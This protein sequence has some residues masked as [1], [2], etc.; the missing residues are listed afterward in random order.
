[1]INANL[2]LLHHAIVHQKAELFDYMPQFSGFKGNLQVKDDDIAYFKQVSPY[3]NHIEQSFVLFQS[4]SLSWLST[5]D[6]QL[7]LLFQKYIHHLSVF[8]ALGEKQ[9][10]YNEKIQYLENQLNTLYLAETDCLFFKQIK[11][12]LHL[13]LNNAAFDDLDMKYLLNIQSWLESLYHE[14][15]L[16]EEQYDDVIFHGEPYFSDYTNQKIKLSLKKKICQLIDDFIQKPYDKALILDSIKEWNGW[17]EQNEIYILLTWLEEQDSDEHFAHA[18]LAIKHV[19]EQKHDLLKV[20]EKKYDISLFYFEEI[21]EAEDTS[22]FLVEETEIKHEQQKEQTVEYRYE[23]HENLEFVFVDCI[24]EKDLD[25]TFDSEFE[26]KLKSLID[27]I[28]QSQVLEID[29]VIEHTTQMQFLLWD[30]QLMS[31]GFTFY[32]LSEYCYFLKNKGQTQLDESDR[33]TIQVVLN[34]MG[35]YFYQSYF[36]SVCLSLMVLLKNNKGFISPVHTSFAEI[37]GNEQ[38]NQLFKHHGFSLYGDEPTPSSIDNYQEPEIETEYQEEEEEAV[39][40]DEP[41]IQ[42]NIQYQEKQP[43]YQEKPQQRTMIQTESGTIQFRPE[44]HLF[45]VNGRKIAAQDFVNL[46]NQILSQNDDL[47]QYLKKIYQGE[48]QFVIERFAVDLIEEIFQNLLKINL[49]QSAS[50]FIQYRFLMLFLVENQIEINEEIFYIAEL[51]ALALHQLLT[52]QRNQDLSLNKEDFQHQ[53]LFMQNLFHTYQNKFNRENLKTQNEK[54][55]DDLVSYMNDQFKELF[56]ALNSEM[57]TTYELS[58]TLSTFNLQVNKVLSEI[59]TTS[60]SS[61]DNIKTT[62]NELLELS[63][64]VEKNL[65]IIQSNLKDI[66]ELIQTIADKNNSRRGLFG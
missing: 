43:T 26:E 50:L 64:I 34:V 61:H 48:N 11:E 42:K 36:P 28:N 47:Y 10:H 14:F 33:K 65:K 22:S 63:E 12:R 32:I 46:G 41:V 59:V 7:L 39:I 66:H 35:Q 62:Q 23:T 44:E 21:E 40:H 38:I 17:L 29:K 4:D 31:N 24:D 58:K 8:I 9:H 37:Y 51:N 52:E 30:R 25:L 1:M 54:I 53:I 49:N 20:F 45:V 19:L 27:Y 16:K 18:L 56:T 15:W 5:R 6:R 55:N 57:E 13:V 60:N 3:L 2:I